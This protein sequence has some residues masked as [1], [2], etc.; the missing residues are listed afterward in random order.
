MA[1]RKKT[2]FASGTMPVR[3]SKS[4][5]GQKGSSRGYKDQTKKNPFSNLFAGKATAKKKKTRK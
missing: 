4:S 5:K 2:K 1:P 3:A